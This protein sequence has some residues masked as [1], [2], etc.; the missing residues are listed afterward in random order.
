[1]KLKTLIEY[2]RCF[3][4]LKSGEMSDNSLSALQYLEVIKA[5]SVFDLELEQHMKT[6]SAVEVEAA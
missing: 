1:M 6:L 5:K 2:Q 4:L 3:E